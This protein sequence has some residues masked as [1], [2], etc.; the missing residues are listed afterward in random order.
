MTHCK[1]DTG[2]CGN[3]PGTDSDILPQ[4]HPVRGEIWYV[5][6]PI[7]SHCWAME[8]AWRKLLYHYGD[9]FTTRYLYGGL[10]PDW[11]GFADS[12]AGVY[13]P[14]D[15]APHW[16]EVARHY[17]QPIDPAVWLR[18]PLAS[19]YPPSI[20][21]HVVRM[22]DA[23]REEAFL[24]RLREALFLEARN[25]ARL[26]VLLECA[27]D[28]KLDPQQFQLLYQSGIAERAF[29]RDLQEVRQLPVSGFPTLIFRGLDGKTLIVG[30]TQPYAQLEQ[31]CI[32]V[33]GLPPSTKTPS[34]AE[35]LA[36]YSAGTTQEFANVL[37]LGSNE[38]AQALTA[39]GAC[40]IPAAGD[41][42]WTTAESETVWNFKNPLPAN[43]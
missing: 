14:A 30:G 33:T 1:L 9:H 38:T 31:A 18:D 36:A 20:A 25:I 16:T 37:N 32:Q 15:V 2:I 35:A 28:S 19:S 42:I 23:R 21:A 34:A 24:R 39:V 10:L 29:Q 40:R 43:A 4:T 27:K 12:G 11:E 22:L 13:R 3:M 6:D 17:G 7:C 26:E 8:P 41:A 5:T